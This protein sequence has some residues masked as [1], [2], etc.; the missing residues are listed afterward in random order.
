MARVLLV[1]ELGAGYGHLAQLRRIG[2]AVQARGHEIAYA[3]RSLDE[4]ADVLGVTAPMFQ[5]PLVGPNFALAGARLPL[6]SL[7]DILY[8]A[9]FSHARTLMPAVRAWEMLLG[10]VAPDVIV[11]DYAPVATLA[12]WSFVP[13]LAVGSGFTLPPRHLTELPPLATRSGPGVPARH[14]LEVAAQIQAARRAPAPASL[15]ELL[16]GDRGFAFGLDLFDPYRDLRL[17]PLCA[18]LEPLPAP[19]P[20]PADPRSA[21][22]Y[23]GGDYAPTGPALMALA[24]RAKDEGIRLGAYV[25]RGSLRLRDGLAALGVA[26]HD[27][28]PPLAEVLAGHG[29]VVHHGGLGTAAAALAAG[30]PQVLFTQHLEHGL[31][32]AVLARLGCGVAV[33]GRDGPAL[34]ARAVTGVLDDPQAAERAAAAATTRREQ[35]DGLAP[36]LD[37][38]D[39]LGGRAR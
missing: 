20:P 39:T 9:G 15:G 34:L 24:E 4:A 21:F 7:P 3:V 37:A 28:P 18:P 38:I 26:V 2:A 10:L 11:A 25:R 32:G 35:P 27:R 33:E 29:A 22:V 12:A 5:A 1:W 30:R 23:L 17:E 31:N 8:A 14:I 13:V 36:L 6:S 16:G 19:L